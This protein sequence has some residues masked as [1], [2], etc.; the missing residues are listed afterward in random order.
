M[1]ERASRT[2]LAA[3][4]H[5]AAHQILDEPLVFR[6]PCALKVIGPRLAAEIRDFPQQ[7]ATPLARSL[8]AA[9]V[10]RS[11]YAED[12][13][14]ACVLHGELRQY[15]LLG[16]GLDTFAARNPWPDL[17]VF[18]VDHPATQRWKIEQL[19]EGG[20][21]ILGPCSFVPLEFGLES[22][23][24]ALARGG[25]AVREPCFYSCLGVTLYLERDTVLSLL[26]CVAQSGGSI[27]LDYGISPRML[28]TRVRLGIE[29][30]AQRAAAAGEPWRTRFETPELH[31]QLRA[32]GFR[33]IEERTPEE[34]NAKYF[35]RRSD[36]LCTGGSSRLLYARV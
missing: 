12:C 11:R 31:A 24:E 1:P 27:V 19:E 23:S 20:V 33:R 22:L 21:P 10:A 36:G 25:V 29:A 35:A 6:D 3:A 14:Q 34:L 13:L 8:R 32:M 2:A 26:R 16:A 28:S 17:R 9:I 15:V 7:F 18:E 30:L 4:T 5:R